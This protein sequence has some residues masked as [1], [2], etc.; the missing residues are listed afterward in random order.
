MTSSCCFDGLDL[1]LVQLQSLQHTLHLAQGHHLTR[2]QIVAGIQQLGVSV[3]RRFRSVTI[4]G[5][6]AAEQS[7]E[8][9]SRQTA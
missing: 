9:V 1:L 4:G 6:K 7:A 2:K 5:F 3:L 8:P